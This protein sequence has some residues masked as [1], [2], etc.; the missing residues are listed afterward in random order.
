MT[1][2]VNLADKYPEIVKELED[3]MNGMRIPS[4]NWPLPE[5]QK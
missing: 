2:S 4:P 5:E 1:E 3:E